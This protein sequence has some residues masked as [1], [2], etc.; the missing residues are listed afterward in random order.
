M[1]GVVQYR[2][3]NLPRYRKFVQHVTDRV[4]CTGYFTTDYNNMGVDYQR[5]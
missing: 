5:S 2:I 1:G 4:S 3:P